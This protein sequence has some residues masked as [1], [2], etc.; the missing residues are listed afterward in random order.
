VTAGSINPN[1]FQ[2]QEYKFGAFGNPDPAVRRARSPAGLRGD[3]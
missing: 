2:G 1:L 3:R